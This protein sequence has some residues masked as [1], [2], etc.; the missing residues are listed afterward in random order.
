MTNLGNS[1]DKNWDFQQPRATFRNFGTGSRPPRRCV[2]LSPHGRQGNRAPTATQQPNTPLKRG[3]NWHSKF[4]KMASVRTELL[5]AP[6]VPKTGD[7]EQPGPRGVPFPRVDVVRLFGS[8]GFGLGVAGRC[9]GWLLPL[10]EALEQQH[11]RAAHNVHTRTVPVLRGRRTRA[12]HRHGQPTA[13]RCELRVPHRPS[14]AL[15]SPAKDL[16]G[17]WSWSLCDVCVLWGGNRN[18]AKSVHGTDG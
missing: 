4:R 18:A 9:L 3:R 5:G 17:V 8:L 6:A 12:A 15:E 10:V 7:H 11:L 13:P 14:T 2:H 1:D 16:Q